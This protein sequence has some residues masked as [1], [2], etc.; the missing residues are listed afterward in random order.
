MFN[1]GLVAGEPGARG[2]GS[3]TR[4]PQGLELRKQVSGQAFILYT[5]ILPKRYCRIVLLYNLHP[6]PI[7]APAECI[8]FSNSA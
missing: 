3:D 5:C 8:N 1:L 4:P 2:L 7:S 6:P